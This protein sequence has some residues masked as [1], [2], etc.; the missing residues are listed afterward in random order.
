[1]LVNRIWKYTKIFVPIGLYPLLGPF[2]RLRRQKRLR[3]LEIKDQ[4]FLVT[5]PGVK[6]PSAELRYNVVGAYDIPKFLDMGEQTIRDIEHALE[7]AG[8]SLN[9]TKEFLDFGCGCGRLIIALLRFRSDHGLN[10]NITGCDVDQRAV[11]WCQRN[12]QSSRCV[13]NQEMPPLMF[14]DHTFD[15]IWCGSVFTHLDEAHQN[16]WLSELKRVL[17]PTGIL[18]ASVHGRHSW[19]SR[20]PFWTRA[21]LEKK[22]ILF[23]KTGANKGIHPDWYQ[24]TWHTEAYVKQHWSTLFEVCAYL[25][26][27][28]NNHQDIVVAR[29][30]CELNKL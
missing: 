14:S 9:R 18:I 17:K 29:N 30:K 10:L 12:L 27:A 3:R 16:L 5:H 24:V 8:G 4:H 22:G 23:A 11:E 7:N 15:V 21:K 26:R 13:V 20:L 6:M 1:M 25:P 2:Y 19:E 28:F